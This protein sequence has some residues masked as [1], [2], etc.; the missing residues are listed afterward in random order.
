MSWERLLRVGG[1]ASRFTQVRALTLLAY[2]LPLLPHLP[3]G[4][5]FPTG[6]HTEEASPLGRVKEK[7]CLWYHKDFG[8]HCL[9]LL[10]IK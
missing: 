3:L 8:L 10:F 5:S 7:G 2:T 4:L 1:L 9:I 6:A